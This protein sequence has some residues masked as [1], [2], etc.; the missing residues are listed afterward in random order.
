MP[1]LNDFKSSFKTDLAR[2]SRFNV[3]IPIPSGLLSGNLFGGDDS[4]IPFLQTAADTLL[5]G[6]EQSVSVV[7]E[8]ITR[9]STIRDLVFR[10]EN[11]NLPGR[12]LATADQRIYGPIEKHPY[13]S[14]YN[15]IDL[16]FIVSDTMNEKFLFDDWIEYINPKNTNNFRYREQ[17]QTTLTINQYDVNDFPSYTVELYEAFPISINQMDL[18]WSNNGYHRITVTFAYTSW[19]NSRGLSNNILLNFT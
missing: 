1:S 19:K 6:G 13:L 15:D 4:Q 9:Y 18:D 10:C 14:T 3:M 8:K 16:T 2:P 11:A 17:Y 5:E 7:A 12:S